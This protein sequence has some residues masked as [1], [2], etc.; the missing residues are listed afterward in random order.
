MNRS[1][2]ITLSVFFLG[3]ALG[4]RTFG[5]RA[6]RYPHPLRV[7]AALEVAVA[8]AALSFFFLFGAAALSARAASSISFARSS[9]YLVCR[10]RISSM[11]RI[12]RTM[13]RLPFEFIRS[14]PAANTPYGMAKRKA[15]GTV[16]RRA[17]RRV[18]IR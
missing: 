18:R 2:A 12:S 1:A 11:T 5:Q 4:N 3:L 17:P 8:V 10:S 15:E 6:A 9:A 13:G 16:I 14:T 7:Y